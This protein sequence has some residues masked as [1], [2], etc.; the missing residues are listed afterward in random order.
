M[1]CHQWPATDQLPIERTSHSRVFQHI[2]LDYLGPLYTKDASNT[3]I[4]VWINLY[5]CMTTRAIHLEVVESLSTQC[6]IYA[7]RRFV[8]RRGMPNLTLSDNAT[9]FKHAAR[10]LDSV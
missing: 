2:G 4:K 7:F 8:S 6:F 3:H 9:Q 1:P 10:A 5:T